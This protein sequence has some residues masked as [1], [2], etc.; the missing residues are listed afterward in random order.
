MKV[1]F[2]RVLSAQIVSNE[3]DPPC[4]GSSARK[5]CRYCIIIDL[6]RTTR[7]KNHQVRAHRAIQVCS[8]SIHWHFSHML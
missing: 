2:G 4:S 8:Y 1:H 3:F 5:L 6:Q 7:I